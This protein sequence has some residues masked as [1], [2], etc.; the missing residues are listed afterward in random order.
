VLS[1]FFPERIE[2]LII[3]NAPPGFSLLFSLVTQLMSKRTQSRV[4]VVDA[5]DEARRRKLLHEFVDPSQLPVEYDGT[6]T[7]PGEGG[8][9][10]NHPL[11]Q[12][13]WTAVEKN[14][15]PETRKGL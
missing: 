11:E 10:R 4:V 13:L 1:P 15:P 14:T 9:W 12:Q 3:V 6:C 8:C 7:C 2:K 5:G